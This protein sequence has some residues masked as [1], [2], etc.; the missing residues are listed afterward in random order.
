MSEPSFSNG[1][2]SPWYGGRIKHPGLWRGCVGSWSPLL[3]PTGATLFSQDGRC[4]HATLMNPVAS[5]WLVGRYGH[6]IDLSG[7]TDYVSIPYSADYNSPHIAFS[8]WFRTT[9]AGG[10]LGIVSRWQNISGNYS[11]VLTSEGATVI[12]YF[13]GFNTGHIGSSVNNGEWQNITV[14]YDKVRMK[15]WQNGKSIYD[16]AQT[17]TWNTT[18]ESI[19]I[20]TY[21]RGGGGGGQ[22]LNMQLAS[23]TH[24]NR[25]L[26]DAE[27][28]LLAQRPGIMYEIDDSDVW[29][30]V[31]AGGSVPW[32]AFA[33]RQSR[34]IGGGVT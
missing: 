10:N 6:I 27:A 28:L 32:W 9:S 16:T 20:G 17:F 24:W 11:W 26:N 5:P 15:V 8:I 2:A 21:A 34:I 30:A 31:E 29:G 22:Q 18:S 1:F 25:G 12:L 3:G 14:S 33:N 7:S 23:F 13:A 19:E 4:N